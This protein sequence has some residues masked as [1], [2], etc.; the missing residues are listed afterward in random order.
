LRDKIP[1][2]RESPFYSL[3]EWNHIKPWVNIGY[4]NELGQSESI[5]QQDPVAANWFRGRLPDLG[6]F[7]IVRPTV[8]N[9]T[10][11][12]AKSDKPEIFPHNHEALPQTRALFR[13]M[14]LPYEETG[15]GLTALDGVEVDPLTSS[16]FPFR[17]KKQPAIKEH[18]PYFRW[19]TVP[20]NRDRPM[21]IYVANPKIEYLDMDAINQGKIRIFRNPPLDYLL[22]EK[23]YFQRQTEA[24]MRYP[25]PTWSAL[26]FVKEGGGWHYFVRGLQGKYH[27]RG[28]RRWFIRWDV[29]SWD[30]S[31]GPSLDEEVETERLRFF[32]RPLTEREMYDVSWLAEEACLS[33]E[34]LPNGQVVSTALSQKSGRFKTSDNN[35]M[36]HTFIMIFHYVRMCHKLGIEP[37]FKHMM[38]VMVLRLYSDDCQAATDYPEFFQEEDLRETLAMF[39]MTLKEYVISDDPRSIQFLGASNMWWKDHWVPRY[40]SKRM[41][42]ALVYV[43]GRMSDRERTQRV[44]GLAHNVAFD[45]EAATLVV[46]FAEE[47]RKQGR[48]IGH[49]MITKGDM[50]VAFNPAGCPDNQG[51][52]ETVVLHARIK[53]NMN[54]SSRKA[55]LESLVADKVLTPEGKNWLIEATD[56]FHDSQITLTGFPDMNVAG[57]VVQ[58][59]TKTQT[60]K[61]PTACGAGNWDTNIVMWP[62]PTQVTT[63]G[64]PPNKPNTYAV[65]TALTGSNQALEQDTQDLAGAIQPY[66]M[67]GVTAFCVTSG[68]PTYGS[69]TTSTNEASACNLSL[70]TTFLKGNC[71]VI[72][73]GM[74]VVNTTA[75]IYKQ[76]QVTVYRQP[77][78]EPS[79]KYSATV[80]QV[81]GSVAPD[82][83]KWTNQEWKNF[84]RWLAMRLNKPFRYTKEWMKDHKDDIP[85]MVADFQESLEKKKEKR[86]SLE[87]EAPAAVTIHSQGWHSTYA[88]SQPPSTQAEAM[89][90]AG[91]QQWE[92]ASGTYNVCTMNTIDNPAKFPE[93]QLVVA[94][95][96]SVDNEEAATGLGMSTGTIDADGPDVGFPNV[97]NTQMVTPFNL[98]GAFYT[99]L[100]D[101]TT[102][103]ITAKWYVERFPDPFEEDLVVLA[104]PSPGND[105][106]A[107]DIY[108]RAMRSMPV[109][110][111]QG[112]NPLGEW[113][114]NVV[115]QI[116]RT[117]APALKAAGAIN[118]LMGGLGYVAENVGEYLKPQPAK[119][120]K[121]QG[122]QPAPSAQNKAVVKKVATPAPPPRPPRPGF[123]QNYTGPQMQ[124]SRASKKR[125][126][127]AARGVLG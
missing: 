48:W 60:I 37:N 103:A 96:S 1:A 102:L 98:A 83:T 125:M 70:D 62:M 108:A 42:F 12:I 76:G 90:L 41:I 44:A 36:G 22:L 30:K 49:P 113:F 123:N 101:Q 59:I 127:A 35:T 29:G 120:R 94:W 16:G 107:K 110:C 86:K 84:R 53:T 27:T 69:A 89:L 7:G 65:T 2:R 111:K 63:S 54:R 13:R 115:G 25:N 9:V 45:D 8:W 109:A 28:K 93:P 77:N 106:V 5:V 50:R 88:M 66:P 43:G 10:Q 46:E 18:D 126:R 67:G 24:L 92:A 57:S 74:E 91:T 52:K 55:S 58:C 17:S 14:Y 40:D 38:Q 56:P 4:V 81:T 26:G 20:G 72:G 33:L 75:E 19:Y 23:M 64:G 119:Q 87:L 99:G 68:T 51:P 85:R 97:C 61:K 80:L 3:G 47:L 122:S 34:L 6:E 21:P 104:S 121:K 118:P 100:S 71:R 82:H 11:A 105:E 124:P 73:M 32:A 15:Y 116:A 31:Y 39:G 78:P 114:S 112:D 117:V 79:Q 95:T